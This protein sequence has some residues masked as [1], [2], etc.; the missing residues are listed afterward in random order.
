MYVITE[1]PQPSI[2]VSCESFLSPHCLLR[3]ND[4]TLG[5]HCAELGVAND[6]T[7]GTAVGGVGQIGPGRDLFRNPDPTSHRQI[8]SPKQG[9]ENQNSDRAGG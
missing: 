8:I 4:K 3:E 9:P 5:L 1:A 6:R 2:I 7:R